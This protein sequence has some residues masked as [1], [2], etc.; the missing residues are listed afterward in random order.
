METGEIIKQL[1]KEKGITQ[2][3]LANVLGLQKSAIAKYEN[4][5][6]KNIKRE[7]INA[8]AV[9]FGVKPSYILGETEEALI[10]DADEIKMV[11][12]YRLAPENIRKAVDIL[13]EINTSSK[14]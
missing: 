4:G 6:V 5:R 9:Y 7:T 12:A 1:R 10:L 8:M 3:E 13:L 2:E 14:G 11:K